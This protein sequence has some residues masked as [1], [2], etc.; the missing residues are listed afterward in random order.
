MR[1]HFGFWL[2]AMLVSGA[3]AGEPLPRGAVGRLGPTLRM[4]HAD[5][6]ARDDYRGAVLSLAFSP[7]GRTLATGTYDD[8]VH[9]W[10]VSTGRQSR[11]LMGH[12]ERVVALSFSS[13]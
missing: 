11:C 6:H 2:M 9:L 12:G 10:D 1:S 13:D 5:E 4:L 3:G 7:D 8:L